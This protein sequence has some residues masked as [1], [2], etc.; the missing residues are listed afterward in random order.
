MPSSIQICLKVYNSVFTP[1]LTSIQKWNM[2]TFNLGQ[3]LGQQCLK[4]PKIILKTPLKTQHNSANNTCRAQDFHPSFKN[5]KEQ[6]KSGS[7]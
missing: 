1:I 4:I 2:E 3:K 7:T 5:K 6:Q